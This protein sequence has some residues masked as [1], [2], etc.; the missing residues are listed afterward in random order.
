MG[1]QSYGV[2]HLAEFWIEKQPHPYPAF[3]TAYVSAK[4]GFKIG[5]DDL[6]HNLG[7]V[8]QFGSVNL[9][10][11]GCS[12]WCRVNAVEVVHEPRRSKFV[13]Q[14]LR[15]FFRNRCSSAVQFLELNAPFWVDQIGAKSENLTEFYRQ[16]AHGLN[17]VNVHR[18]L[19]SNLTE[20]PEERYEFHV[21]T[22]QSS[23][24][25]VLYS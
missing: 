10:D 7:S 5:F 21:L 23:S 6:H 1:Q 20:E 25:M 11:A 24:S 17:L 12:E 19:A 3:H 9:S 8:L 4:R 22:S 14:P 13:Q 2:A 16:E 15:I 18:L